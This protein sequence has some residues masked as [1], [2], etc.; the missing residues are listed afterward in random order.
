MKKFLSIFAAL[1]LC[2]CTANNDG[3]RYTATDPET[4]ADTSE[5]SEIY[6]V[7]NPFASADNDTITEDNMSISFGIGINQQDFENFTFENDEMV[8]P[9]TIQNEG[10]DINLG[11]LVFADGILQ[12]S[13]SDISPESSSMQIFSVDSKTVDTHELYIEN[14]C[15]KDYAENIPISIISIVNPDFVPTPNNITTIGGHSGYN[16][17]NLP[18]IIKSESIVSDFIIEMSDDSHLITDEEAKRF[19][20]NLDADGTNGGMTMFQIDRADSAGR[21]EGVLEAPEDGVLELKLYAYSLNDLPAKYRIS[22]YKNHELVTFNDKSDYLDIDIRHGYMNICDVTLENVNA[23]DFIYCVA[24]PV[25]NYTIIG[26]KYTTIPIFDK[27]DMPAPLDDDILI[28]EVFP[29][30]TNSLQ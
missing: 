24:V 27:E 17:L 2:G 5:A 12:S 13:T 18:A 19:G 25:D 6:T 11:F 3:T 22:F 30:E 15:L 10:I 28:F 1:L 29:D 4:I 16:A 20:L 8:I 9:L 7:A 14:M 21:P 23:G 26:R